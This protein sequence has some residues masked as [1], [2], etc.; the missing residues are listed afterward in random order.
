MLARRR[1][2]PSIV[3]YRH[4][5]GVGLKRFWA[6]AR[7]YRPSAFLAMLAKR[8]DGAAPVTGVQ[9]SRPLEYNFTIDM[10]TDP[11]TTLRFRI[12]ICGVTSAEDALAAAR[13]GADAIGLNFYQ[14]SKRYITLAEAADIAAASLSRSP[15]AQRV[16]VFVNPSEQELAAAIDAALL[17][18]VQFHGDESPQFIARF[19]AK[20]RISV[21]KAFR[22]GSDG[23]GPIDA[24][25]NQCAGSNCKLA[26][27]LLDSAA[28]TTYGGTGITA[29]WHELAE[30]MQSAQRQHSSYAALPIVLAGGLRPANIAAAI[31][32]VRPAA[33]DTASGVETSPRQKDAKLIADFVQ[34]ANQAFSN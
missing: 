13:A 8:T 1:K 32:A 9:A 14:R 34:A 26:G 4:P 15:K 19:Q 12:K 25:L 20:H 18:F 17:N 6:S 16:G 33:V 7:A 23:A 29:P 2:L 31:A 5:A 11:E 27:I 3:S 21:L 10:A 28:P 24:Y 22:W 30:W